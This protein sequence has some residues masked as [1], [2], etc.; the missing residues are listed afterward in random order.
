MPELSDEFVCHDVIITT[1]A[2]RAIPCH[3]IG[4]LGVHNSLLS[5]NTEQSQ[6]L[7]CLQLY[8]CIMHFD[9]SAVFTCIHIALNSR[10]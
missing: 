4:S 3:T 1:F 6:N 5:A 10:V 9:S 8:G 2:L 7:Y